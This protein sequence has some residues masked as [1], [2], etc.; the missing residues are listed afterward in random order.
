[1]FGPLWQAT[2]DLHHQ[3]EAHPLARAMIDGTITPQAWADWLQAH[4]TI[5]MALDPYLPPA[6]RRAD[7]LAFDLLA[8][9]P[10][11]ARPSPAA[12]AFAATLT[13]TVTIFG[14]AYLTIGAH[15]RGGRVIEKALRTAGRD[16]PSQ[17]TRFEDGAAAEAFVKQLREIPAL[18]PGA[19]RAFTA[20]TRVMD[21]IVARGDFTMAVPETEGQP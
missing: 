2:R 5:Q 14:A 8:L 20:L 17:H 10:V 9:L 1:M 6:V 12:A 3:A 18:A 21:E 7:A 11:E 4:L 19:R 16:L 15:R 13:E